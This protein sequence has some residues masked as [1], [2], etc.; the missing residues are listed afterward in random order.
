[1]MSYGMPGVFPMRSH[2]HPPPG[3]DG[4]GAHRAMYPLAPPSTPALW[5]APYGESTAMEF[6][7]FG[8]I[9]NA[10]LVAMTL[11]GVSLEDRIAKAVG[12][13]GY[14]AIV[15]AAVG[16]AISDGV[17]AIPSGRKAAVSVTL[18][19]LVPVLPLAV[20]MAMKRPLRGNTQKALLASSVGLLALAFLR[21]RE[22]S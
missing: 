12:V 17:A 1:M 21:K 3:I 22:S 8:L 4:L 19:A 14:G 10:L 2:Q 6:G 9:D 15:G 18:G 16:N 7:R 20:A 5:G 13:A 11:A